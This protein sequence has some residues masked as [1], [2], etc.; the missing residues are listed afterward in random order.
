[1]NSR[2]R[3][4]GSLMIDFIAA[5]AV[6]ML[7]T[8]MFYSICA[9]KDRTLNETEILPHATN[10]ANGLMELLRALPRDELLKSNGTTFPVAGLKDPGK[11]P[12]K[13]AIKEF[14][15]GLTQITV[16]VSWTNRAGTYE[17]VQLSTLVCDREVWR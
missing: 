13:V 11:I 2:L 16:T 8:G 3:R 9:T 17:N 14:E 7:V 5:T 6:F 1:M 10:A 12:G 15:P 4:R